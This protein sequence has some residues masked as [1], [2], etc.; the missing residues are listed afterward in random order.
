MGE[1]RQTPQAQITGKETFQ[2]KSPKYKGIIEKK[3]LERLD[4]YE[5]QNR[6]KKSLLERIHKS[7]EH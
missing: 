4:F 7:K 6:N 1:N 5:K 2:F 3:I